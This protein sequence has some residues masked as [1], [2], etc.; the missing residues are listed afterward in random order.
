MA[1]IAANQFAIDTAGIMWLSLC[2]RN[3]LS[4]LSE[5]GSYRDS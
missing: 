3:H 1:P 2:S 4:L 5:D